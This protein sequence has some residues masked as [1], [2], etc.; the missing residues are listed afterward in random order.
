MSGSKPRDWY[1]PA[2][3]FEMDDEQQVANALGEIVTILTRIGGS[4][5]MV[6]H[7]QEIEPGMWA[8]VGYQCRWESFAP[9]DRHRPEVVEEPEL[10]AVEAA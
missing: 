2:H 10:E 8:T 4:M 9:G 3:P 1:I 7:R 5:L 6:A